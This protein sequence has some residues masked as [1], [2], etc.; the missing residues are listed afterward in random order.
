MWPFSPTA[1]ATPLFQSALCL[2]PITVQHW[3][4]CDQA[5]PDRVHSTTSHRSAQLW[6]PLD[7]SSPG[8]PLAAVPVHACWPPSPALFRR[9]TDKKSLDKATAQ[10]AHPPTCAA[11]A[12]QLAFVLPSVLTG[13]RPHTSVSLRRTSVPVALTGSRRPGRTSGC[14]LI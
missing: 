1:C 2:R 9:S 6:R 11:R 4:H 3:P 13:H 12:A 8:L 7:Q 5:R 14:E 10:L